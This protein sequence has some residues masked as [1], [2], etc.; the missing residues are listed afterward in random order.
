MKKLSLVVVGFVVLLS[1]SACKKSA[2]E[3]ILGTWKN[4]STEVN[5]LDQISS[6]LFDLQVNNLKDQINSYSTQLESMDDSSKFAYQQIISN[7]QTQLDGL[8]VDTVKKNIESNFKIGTFTFRDDSTLVI[9]TNMDS[10]DGKWN[11]SED[12]LTLNLEVQTEVVPLK[13]SE[14]SKDKLVIIQSTN[15]DTLNFDVT[16]YFER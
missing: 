15:I 9:K 8:S 10:V 11:I 1:L 13:I 5:K 12:E 14:I 6:F 16:Y 4:T 7:L 2:N 3:T